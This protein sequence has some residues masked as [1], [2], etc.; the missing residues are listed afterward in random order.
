MSVGLSE[1]GA[2]SDPGRCP[3][4]PREAAGTHH[5]LGRKLPLGAFPAAMTLDSPSPPG[6]RVPVGGPGLVAVP[7]AGLEGLG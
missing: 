6:L 7:W 3:W 1:S 2:A 4:R 5:H